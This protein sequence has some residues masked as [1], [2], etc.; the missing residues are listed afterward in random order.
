MPL[1][2]FSIGDF[3]KIRLSVFL[4]VFLSVPFQYFLELCIKIL[5]QNI[6]KYLNP[7]RLQCR[8]TSDSHVA[9][10]S[11]CLNSFVALEKLPWNSLLFFDNSLSYVKKTKTVIILN[12]A[13]QLP[14]ERSPP[15]RLVVDSVLSATKSGN[16]V[17]L[18]LMLFFFSSR[19]SSC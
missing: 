7:F 17:H 16:W 11:Y 13:S 5:F 12:H 3:G 4:C 8:F 19:L 15:C 10:C 14:T 2:I 1:P 9:S 18:S 6:E